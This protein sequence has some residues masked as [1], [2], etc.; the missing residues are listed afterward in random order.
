MLSILRIQNK[1]TA[2][3]GNTRIVL[4]VDSFVLK[5]PSLYHE[6]ALS[7]SLRTVLSL[8]IKSYVNFLP[9]IT[10]LTKLFELN[11]ALFA[12]YLNENA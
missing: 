8:F 9:S 6:N 4:G 2:A 3:T 11:P 12:T 5:Q 10:S 1:R 7:F